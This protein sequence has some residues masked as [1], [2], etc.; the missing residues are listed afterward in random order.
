M[1]R[2][3]TAR[4]LPKSTQPARPALAVLPTFDL[5]HV[6]ARVAHGNPSWSQ[7]RLDDAQNAYRVFCA[8]VKATPHAEH[9]RPTKDVDQ[10][11]HVHITDTRRYAQD[12]ADYF[13]FF[14]HHVPEDGVEMNPDVATCGD[15]V[16]RYRA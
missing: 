1:N 13:G 7:D 4:V 3:T 8:N 11:W 16:E 12:C 15:Y 2:T 9:R 6:M 10:V 5:T 14:L